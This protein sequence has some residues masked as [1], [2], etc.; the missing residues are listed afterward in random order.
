MLYTYFV[1]SPGVQ[2]NTYVKYNPGVRGNY[3]KFG[4][5]NLNTPLGI[6][7]G[8]TTHNP[9]IGIAGVITNGLGHSLGTRIKNDIIGHGYNTVN[10]TEWFSVTNIRAW[11]V[12][13]LILNNYDGVTVNAGNYVAF[14]NAVLNLL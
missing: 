13:N 12:F 10:N 9:D 1:I 6:R 4:D 8:Y 14:R 3:I 7:L 5:T 2:L 11:N